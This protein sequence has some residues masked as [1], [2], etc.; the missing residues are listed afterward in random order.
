[1]KKHPEA[2]SRIPKFLKIGPFKN[3]LQHKILKKLSYSKLEYPSFLIR[4]SNISFFVVF[5]K[6]NDNFLIQRR[7]ACP[8]TRLSATR[9]WAGKLQAELARK[10]E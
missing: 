9:L 1:L 2:K 7:A 8:R 4:S 10:D 3:P 5:F 6:K